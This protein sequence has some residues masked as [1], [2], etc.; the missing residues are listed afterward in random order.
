M[1]VVAFPVVDSPLPLLQRELFAPLSNA[2]TVESERRCCS[3]VAAV[4]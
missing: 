4:V 2:K 3:F 1:K